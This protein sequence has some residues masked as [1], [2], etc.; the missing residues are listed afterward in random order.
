[1]DHVHP[2][3]LMAEI[4]A[5]SRKK[6]GLSVSGMLLKGFLSGALLAYATAFAFKAAAGLEPG[7]AALVAGAVFP[8]GFAMIVLLGLELATGNFALLPVGIARGH[9]GMAAMLRNWGWVY[10]GNFLG[11]VFAGALFAIALTEAFTH[12]AGALGAKLVAVAESKTLAYQA[13]G[14]AGWATAFVKGVLCNWMVALGT[15]LALTSTSNTGKIAAVWLPVS[16]FFALALE[17]SIVNMFVMPTAMLLG[18]DIG[19]GQWLLWNQIP[20]TLG[21]IV[22]GALLTGLLLHFAH[23][24]AAR[25]AAPAAAD[26]SVPA[27][28]ASR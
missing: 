13:A 5:A 3:K 20:V 27:A 2:P 26:A 4:E 21:N 23:G 22:G 10:L 25:N 6:A 14:G 24:T 1:M 16:T 28:A 15:V 19:I 12:G 18:A 17:H 11:C 8:V 9:L 7:L